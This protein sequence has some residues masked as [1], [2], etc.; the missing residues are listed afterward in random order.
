MHFS[1]VFFPDIVGQ[2]GTG[3]N[4]TDSLEN[5][6]ADWK[7]FDS[8]VGGMEP[9]P[10]LSSDPSVVCTNGSV[11][12]RPDELMDDYEDDCSSETTEMHM[13]EIE[14]REKYGRVLNRCRNSDWS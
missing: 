4:D 7:P 14:Q 10:G 13:D 2:A 9:V 1:N 11:D 12:G 5:A 3:Q 6:L 8:A